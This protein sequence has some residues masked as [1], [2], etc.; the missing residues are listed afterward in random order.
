VLLY[1]HLIKCLGQLPFDEEEMK[2]SG[3]ACGGVGKY[4]TTSDGRIVEY[5]VYGSDAPDAMVIVQMHGAAHTGGIICQWNAD[6]LKQLNM[7]GIAPTMANSGFSDNQPDRQICNFPRDD[8]APIL[9]AEGVKK[10]VVDGHSLGTAHAMAIAWFF[11]PD[12]KEHVCV[13]MGLNCP[14]LPSSICLAEHYPCDAEEIPLVHNND[15]RKCMSSWNMTMAAFTNLMP[16]IGPPMVMGDTIF[17]GAGKRNPNTFK[18]CKEDQWRTGARGYLGQGYE[19]LSYAIN[20]LWGFDPRD[21]KTKNVAVWYAKDDGGPSG[22]GCPPV[23]GEY[24]SKFFDNKSGTRTANKCVD[25]GC[26]HWSY[27]PSVGET[28]T[29]DEDTLPK[30]LKMMVQGGKVDLV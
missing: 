25:I 1:G 11:S 20:T 28:Y 14:Y 17:V 22:P 8:V 21:I 29:M 3:A 12:H 13:G 6:L 2:A 24:L 19:A 7:K 4:I 9:K 10:F 15:P 27:A 26:G 23:H 16:G 18:M 30:T 5:I